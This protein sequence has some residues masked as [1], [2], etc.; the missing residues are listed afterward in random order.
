MGADYSDWA[1]LSSNSACVS[2]KQC[3]TN[4]VARLRRSAHTAEVT[5]E[6][7]PDLALTPTSFRK[8]NVPEDADSDLSARLFVLDLQ[9]QLPGV[10][11]LRDWTLGVLGPRPGDVAVD[12][13]CGFGTEVRRLA[14]LVGPGGRSVGVEPDPGLR[15]EAEQRTSDSTSATYVDGEAGALPLADESV[16]VLRCE[17]V[18]QHLSD[19]EG[20]AREFARVLAPG[21]RAVVVDSDWGTAVQSMGHP[22]LVRRLNEFAWSQGAN[23]FAG[24]HLRGQLHR[25]GL[26]V[27][28]DIA[29]TAVVMP[30]E[31]LRGMYLW[32]PIF[33]QA[34]E[35]GAVTADEVARFE[36]D[37][38]NAVDGGDA[39][40]AVT[41][42]GVLARK[43][44]AAA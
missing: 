20:A 19:P 31:V 41:M 30:D 13:G 7:P 39:F 38:Q 35:A 12:V 11:R 24:R 23:P 29:A 27:D 10:Q 43:D 6:P 14:D 18:F 25:A 44:G 42:Y 15:A 34:V 21:G 37:V 9:E 3:A 2:S 26:N 1:A 17:R 22:D 36:T 5:T 33:A 32:R 16:D 28:P 4:Q 40:V 8:G